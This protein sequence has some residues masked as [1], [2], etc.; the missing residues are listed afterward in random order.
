MARKEF[1]SVIRTIESLGYGMV[2]ITHDKQNMEKMVTQD[3]ENNAAKVIRGY[4][5]FTFLLKKEDI[6]DRE[7]VI[8]YS[9]KAGA[10]SKSRAM[11]FADKFEF[12]YE[13]LE[14]ELKKAIA[15]QIEMNGIEVKVQEKKATET[16]SF[17]ELRKSVIDLYTKLVGEENSSLKDVEYVIQKQM[18]GVR[19]SE[20]NESYYDQLLVIEAFMLGIE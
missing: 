19:I 13:N 12:T 17:E 7:T 6:D 10:E 5:D 9:Q 20:A 3:L 11:Y 15:K 4:A 2:I 1:T 18:Q 8:A 14:E 16:R